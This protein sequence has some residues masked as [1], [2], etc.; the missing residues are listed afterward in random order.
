MPNET[1][2]WSPVV[3]FY[4]DSCYLTNPILRTLNFPETLHG[5]YRWTFLGNNWKSLKLPPLPQQA[6]ALT[7]LCFL[8][9]T[10]TPTPSSILI[11]ENRFRTACLSWQRG[12]RGR[13]RKDAFWT[14]GRLQLA[15]RAQWGQHTLLRFECCNRKGGKQPI[16]QTGDGEDTPLHPVPLILKLPCKPEKT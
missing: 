5:C 7:Q 14:Q 9:Q 12:G 4:L 6:D 1:R 13:K 15:L 8:V 2:F 11:L 16:R 10:Q 3:S